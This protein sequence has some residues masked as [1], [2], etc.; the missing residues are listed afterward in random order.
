MALLGVLLLAGCADDYTPA[1]PWVIK[2]QGPPPVVAPPQDRE[3]G[4]EPGEPAPGEEGDDGVVAAG[5]TVPTGLVVLPDGT[6]LV[7][8]R[9]TGRIVHVFPDAA[10]PVELMVVPGLDPTGD[11]GLLGLA[12]SPTYE[13]DQLIYAY[14][15]TAEDNRVVKFPIGGTP[16]P[17]FTGIPKGATHNGGAL[18]F[19]ADGALYIGTGDTGTPDLSADDESLAGKVLRIDIFGEPAGSDAVFTSGH[20]DVTAL[21]VSPDGQLFGTDLIDGEADEV[22]VLAE[23]A[24]YGWPRA[25]SGTVDPIITIDAPGDGL[26]GCALAS[27]AIAV[28]A[29]DGQRIYTSQ[30]NAEHAVQG[31]LQEYIK[32]TY[33]RLRTLVIDSEGVLWVTTNNRDGIGVPIEADDRVLRIPAPPV[34]GGGGGTS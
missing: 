8:E 21:C 9:T 7:G 13:Q 20:S 31:E 19:G 27:E 5:L 11:G 6:A 17:V 30:I 29:L 2:P 18:I 25:L 28:G 32:D 34:G 10:P 14:L 4:G 22:N 16:N 1:G 33:G 12:L 26:G 3:S 24:E 23:D 15:T